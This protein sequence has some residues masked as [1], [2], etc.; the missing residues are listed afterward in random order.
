MLTTKKQVVTAFWAENP[1]LD[2][3]KI[4]YTDG[5]RLYKCTTRCAFNDFVDN[6][7]R[8]GQITDEMRMT[9]NLT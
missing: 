5:V 3:E 9:V 2:R 4:T 8:D 1:D 6:L 7:A